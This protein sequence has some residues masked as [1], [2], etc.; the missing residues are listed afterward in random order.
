MRT[1]AKLFVAL[2]VA[3]VA[4]SG[5]SAL[6][7]KKGI[8][9]EMRVGITTGYPPLG[10]EKD[11]QVQG[12]EV[13]FA[14]MLGEE[15]GT[16]MVLVPMPL[17]DLIPALED[18]RIDIIMAG[19]SVTKTRSEKVGFA[20]PYAR[21]GQ[22]ALIR[23]DDYLK[24]RNPNSMNWPTSRV[25]VKSGTTGAKFAKT[26]LK[27]AKITEFANVDD[28]IAALRAGEIDFFIHDAPTVWRV[29]GTPLN[30]DPQLIGLYTPLTEEYLAWAVR[31]DD[32]ELRQR[33]S[34]IV[35]EWKTDG[36]IKPVL[37]RW[38]P[39]RKVT[40]DAAAPPPVP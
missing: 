18:D 20:E 8:P 1:F 17:K 5:C 28:G 25:G 19:M 30:P 10:F 15:L 40:K 37:D 38:V 34:H 6:S 33:L 36:K 13:D 29:A 3:A 2:T 26:V 32:P 4:L 7:S 27:G 16:K 31:K 12:I 9:A 24:L 39:I 11:G 21:V 35:I 23:S 14:R 22:M